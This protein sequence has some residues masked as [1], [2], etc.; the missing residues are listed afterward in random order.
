MSQ[1]QDLSRRLSFLRMDDGAKTA[2]RSAQ[3]AVRQAIGPSLEAFYAQV[4]RFPETAGM[5]Q[6][7]GHMAQAQT[8]QERH[9]DRIMSGAFD[10]DYVESVQRIGAVHARI[11][12]EPRW[13]I[14]GYGLVIEGLIRELVA[15]AARQRKGLQRWPR[16]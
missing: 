14:G 1:D 16:L 15:D 3:G 6:G 4:R 2:L 9:W 11:G 12:L 7:D 10:M 5:F 13:Y 8:A